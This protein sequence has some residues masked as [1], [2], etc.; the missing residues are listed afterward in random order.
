MCAK[1]LCILMSTLPW[2]YFRSHLQ[3][4]RRK[5]L[6][7]LKLWRHYHRQRQS[8]R[9][10]KQ[11]WQRRKKCSSSCNIELSWYCSL[12]WETM[13]WLLFIDLILHSIVLV[14]I[15]CWYKYCNFTRKPI[16]MC[17]FMIDETHLFI[18]IKCDL[19]LLILNTVVF[20]Q[21][22]ALTS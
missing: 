9:K 20:I 2:E 22:W 19:A 17:L 10:N 16:N 21:L 6:S 1:Y 4:W 18:Q 8:I 14:A 12:Y 3:V 13:D 7:S 5:P 15:L 11:G